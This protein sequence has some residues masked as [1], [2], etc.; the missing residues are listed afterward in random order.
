MQVWRRA[1]RLLT[2]YRMP[3]R[4]LAIRLRRRYRMPVRR[5]AIRLRTRLILRRRMSILRGFQGPASMPPDTAAYSE[6]K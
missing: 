1:I 5:L 4:R 6:R 3:G 2:R